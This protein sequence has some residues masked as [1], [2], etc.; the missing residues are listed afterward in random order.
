M[1]NGIFLE[2]K[3]QFD[4]GSVRILESDFSR[5]KNFQKKNFFRQIQTF[6]YYYFLYRKSN[7]VFHV[8][9][10][11]TFFFSKM[12]VDRK[13]ILKNVQTKYKSKN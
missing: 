12:K 5:I 6:L 10:K 7:N 13:Q 11:E 4:L 2:E 8:L 9:G 1:K 3:N